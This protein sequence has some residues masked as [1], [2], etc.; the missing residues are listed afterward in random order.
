MKNHASVLALI[1]ALTTVAWADDFEIGWW[2]VDGG[3]HMWSTGGGFSLGGTIGQPDA[4][5]GPLTSEA[6]SLVGGFW[7]VILPLCTSFAPVD[8]DQ[9]CD[10]DADDFTKFD[11][12][13]TGPAILGP[14]PSGCTAERFNTVDFDDD[15]DVDQSDFSVFQRCYGGSGIPVD[16]SCTG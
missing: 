10:V 7:A 14:P 8:F 5:P 3:G 2:T 1:L 6:L 13:F 16:P 12:C 15:G 4:N 11:A 9:D